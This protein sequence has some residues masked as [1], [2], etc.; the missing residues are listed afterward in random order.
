MTYPAPTTMYSPKYHSLSALFPLS[1]AT[2]MALQSTNRH[3]ALDTA[4]N[5]H[6]PSPV[7]PSLPARKLSLSL[8]SRGKY[9]NAPQF[10]GLPLPDDRN[11][12]LGNMGLGI[13]GLPASNTLQD[14]SQTILDDEVQCPNK[15]K[16]G[17]LLPTLGKPEALDKMTQTESDFLEQDGGSNLLEQFKL[18]EGTQFNDKDQKYEASYQSSHR[19]PSATTQYTTDSDYAS[20]QSTHPNSASNRPHDAPFSKNEALRQ[21][22]L[23][24]PEKP[25]DLRDNATHTGRRHIINGYHAYYW[26]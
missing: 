10:A 25:P 1:Q 19:Q 8:D 13:G 17:F 2:H 15:A 9:A 6:F 26:Q 5:G 20:T 23:L 21:F 18:K 22:R 4:Y 24:Y 12:P 3:T 14:K 16:V 11:A 7:V